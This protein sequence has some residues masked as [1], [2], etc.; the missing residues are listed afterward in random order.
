MSRENVEIVRRGFEE[1]KQGG[2]EAMIDSFWAPEI[3]WDMTE[4][5]IPGYGTYNGY[6]EIKA[7]FADW[8][9]AFE[10]WEF[11]VEEL[12]DCD[13]RVVVIARQRGLGS[14]S[15]AEVGLKFAQVITLRAGKTVRVVNYLDRGEALEAAGL[16]E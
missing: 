14:S 9:S 3:I 13:D 16:S 2:V 8:F 15:G 7:F 6:D 5:G 4:T 10:E 1:F 11:E 12:F